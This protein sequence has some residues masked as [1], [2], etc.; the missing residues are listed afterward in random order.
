MP[1]NGFLLI[2]AAQ[3]DANG[4][5]SLALRKSGSSSKMRS[6]L[7]ARMPSTEPRSTPA[8]MA[9]MMWAD[10]LIDCSRWHGGRRVD[11]QWVGSL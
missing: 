5:S 4:H 1:Y 8:W 7:K 6:R 2:R 9:S 11:D 3:R 10:E